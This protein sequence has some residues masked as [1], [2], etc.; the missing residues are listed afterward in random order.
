MSGP[1]ISNPP[2]SPLTWFREGMALGGIAT[3]PAG[4]GDRLYPPR[5][6]VGSDF[7]PIDAATLARAGVV[8]SVTRIEAR[9]GVF[10]LA[11]VD[12]DGGGRLLARLRTDVEHGS[13]I[14]QRVEL[15]AERRE[16]EPFLTFQP[17][18]AGET[19]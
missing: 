17:E 4:S 10:T 19:A 13:S 7:G 3:S 15:V 14:G 12:L 16:G 9:T 5:L 18:A 6:A 1:I 2:K 11:L 8:Y